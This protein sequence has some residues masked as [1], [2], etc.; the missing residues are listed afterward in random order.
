MFEFLISEEVMIASNTDIEVGKPGFVVIAIV[1]GQIVGL[2][3]VLYFFVLMAISVE[4]SDLLH[5]VEGK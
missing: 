3:K 5:K 4:N 1:A 2:E